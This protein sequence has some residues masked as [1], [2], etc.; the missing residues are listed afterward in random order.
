MHVRGCRVRWRNSTR[1][2]AAARLRDIGISRLEGCSPYEIRGL[3]ETLGLRRSRLP[4]VGFV[5]GVIGAAI[6]YLVQW[7]VDAF[8][9]PLDAGGRP[10]HAIPSFVFVTFETMVLF[11]AVS[12]FVSLMVLAGLPRYYHPLWEIDGFERVSLDRFWVVVDIRQAE[13]DHRQVVET[14]A[15]TRIVSL[16]T[17]R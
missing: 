11:A 5:A 16:R 7:Y 6:G 12:V 10:P 9:Y 1:R 8:D 3:P 13:L 14:L 2:A 17:T 4:T 15:P